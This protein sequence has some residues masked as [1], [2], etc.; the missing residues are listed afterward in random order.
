MTAQ[1]NLTAGALDGI[2]VLD[3]T[4][5]IAGPYCA[6]LMADLGAEVVKIEA[7]IGDLLRIASP[8]RKGKTPYFAQL[9]AG[10]DSVSIDLKKPGAI[11][12]VLDLAEKAD[13]AIQNFRP[14]V[15]SDYGLGYEDLKVRKPDI[16]YCNLSGYGQEGPG[17]N[18]SAYAPIVHASAG[19]D[20]TMISH[21]EGVDIPL[22]GSIPFADYLTGVHGATAI[23]AA[24]FRRERTGQ[25]EEIDIAMADVI[26]NVQAFELQEHQHPLPV[27]RL[28]YRALSAKDGYFVVTPLS[29]KN[30]KDLIKSVGHP[31]WAEEIPLRGPD[32]ASNWRKLM[33]AL[34]EWAVD[35]TAAECEKIISAGGCP[36]AKYQTVLEAL[37]SEQ[38][39]HR[40]SC[41][42]MNDGCGSFL[43]PN[44][45][46]RMKQADASIKSKVSTLGQ[47]NESILQ[48]WLDMSANEIDSLTQQGVLFK[49]KPRS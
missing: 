1:S 37:Q 21:Q 15:L 44:T 26:F 46:L 24:L 28:I 39:L 40:G 7:P 11:D 4:G 45:P 32:F 47:D 16:I 6:R 9:N 48:A 12:L 34:E 22:N 41:V 49:P 10:K 14:G 5:V 38:S 33:D 27:D 31:E 20:L 18:H 25:G 29:E 30:F 23:M 19:L 17:K 2:R 43:V 36:V 8:R 42:E 3:F 13:V 35:R